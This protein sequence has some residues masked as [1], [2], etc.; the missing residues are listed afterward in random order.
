[1]KPRYSA[2]MAGYRTSE[3]S[4]DQVDYGEFGQLLRQC[5]MSRQWS[6]RMLSAQADVN[7]GTL[8]HTEN[9]DPRRILSR[10]TVAAVDDA[11]FADGPLGGH[12]AGALV[13]AW[14][15][16]PS[17]SGVDAAGPDLLPPAPTPFIGRRDVLESVE[18][19]VAVPAETPTAHVAVLTGPGGVGKTATAVVAAHTVRPQ[20]QP[21]GCLWADLRGWDDSAGPRPVES[22]LRSW[23]RALG[24]AEES[25]AGDADELVETWRRLSA[26]HRLLVVA[27][28]ARPEQI[29]TLVPSRSDSLLLITSRDRSAVVDGAQHHD[30]EPLE[31]AEAAELLAA[32][33]GWPSGDVAAL[34]PVC[35]GLPLALVTA[36]REAVAHWTRDGVEDMAA[37][38]GAGDEL[39]AIDRATRLSYNQLDEQHRR[40][41]RW[42]SLLGG[43][44]SE[45]QAAAVVG[46]DARTARRSLT[47]LVDACLLDR[48]AGG[49]DYLDPHRAFARREAFR[50]DTDADREAAVYRGLTWHLHGLAHAAPQLAGRDDTPLELLPLPDGVTAPVFSD[51]DSALAWTDA[52]WSWPVPAQVA[53]EHGWT[54]LA[55][56]LVTAG[57][58][59]AYVLKPLISWDAAAAAVLTSGHDLS[60]EGRA[61]CHHARGIAAGDAGDALRAVRHLL[62]ALDLRRGLGE[63]HRRDV[64]WSALNAARWQL[65]ADAADDDV[66][67]LIDEGLVAHTAIDWTAGLMLGTSLRGAVAER[68]GDWDTAAEHYAKAHAYTPR[69]ADPAIVT[70]TVTALAESLLHTTPPDPQRALR[71]AHDAETHARDTGLVWGRISALLVLA[72]AD[73]G[74]AHTALTTALHLATSIRD[75]RAEH[76][77]DLLDRAA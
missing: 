38:L 10:A 60:D 61:W 23:C 27:D 54:Q 32:R 58:S 50:V 56:Q 64:G 73:P 9:G 68:R 3:T 1:M 70:W 72:R 65:A 45:D 37:D 52:H 41:W 6:L 49:V 7:H 2:S 24:V 29:S 46:T 47:A 77:H 39:T 28:N 13:R 34:V 43:V 62:I 69:V 59:A 42:C 19:C 15:T 14:S 33:T 55:W 75:G 16:L 57:I 17:K 40:V 25:L 12:T 71:L 21:H 31:E 66:L 20:V 4:E 74:Q 35:G 48:V 30:L 51:Y 76:I 63:P 5:R 26:A 18:S 67:P 53:L 8:S 44:L 11:L 36:A 22:V